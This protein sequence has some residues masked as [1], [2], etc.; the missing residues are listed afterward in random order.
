MVFTLYDNKAINVGILLDLPFREGIRA[1]TSD[2]A[3]PHHKVDL[4]NTPTWA[5]VNS[6][7]V[8]E[9]DGLTEYLQSLGAGSADLDF[10]NGD[11]SFGVWIKCTDTGTSEMIIGRYVLSN[12]GWEIYLFNNGLDF[13]LTL[14]H[15]HAAGATTRTACFSTGWTPGAWLFI[16]ISRQGAAA[17]HYRNGVAVPTTHGVGGLIDPEPCV[18]DMVIGARYTKNA[19]FYRG[20]MW[21]PRIW[22]RVL[23]PA[24]WKTIYEL[25]RSKFV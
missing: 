8:L 19:D 6:L 5:N 3:K 2:I 11:Y 23:T 7:G 24:E 10:T 21:R 13:T 12:N 1:R 22:N 9:L 16:G 17:I 18:G 4:V 20:Q 15:H 14:R 25:E